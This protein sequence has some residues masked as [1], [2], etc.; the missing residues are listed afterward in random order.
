M[1]DCR[2][3]VY[4]RAAQSANGSRQLIKSVIKRIKVETNGISARQ[5][6]SCMST[7]AGDFF[8][9]VPV[10][11]RSVREC[12]A[13]GLTCGITVVSCYILCLSQSCGVLLFSESGQLDSDIGIFVW[14]YSGVHFLGYL[15]STWAFSTFLKLDVLGR[16]TV[17]R[18]YI[19]VSMISQTEGQQ[20][21]YYLPGSCHLVDVA[22]NTDPQSLWKQR[23]VTNSSLC[24][25]WSAGS[26]DRWERTRVI[27]EILL[28][29]DGHA[30]TRPSKDVRLFFDALMEQDS[31]DHHEWTQPQFDLL[32]FA[33]PN[34]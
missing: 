26:H 19:K 3:D 33:H 7:N 2:C 30:H 18:P 21:L 12:A 1:H 10:T 16:G 9:A 14:A 6:K 29:S 34:L 32:F 20:L 31:S 25:C 8:E 11:W 22:H 28:L 13:V 15:L 5:E 17:K 4:E 23:M 27:V 24:T